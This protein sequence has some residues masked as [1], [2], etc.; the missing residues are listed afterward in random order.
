M[1]PSPILR[2][3]H[4]RGRGTV[5]RFRMAALALIVTVGAGPMLLDA[6]ILATKDQ[7]GCAIR[8]VVDGDT[9]RL[10]CPDLGRVNGRV[11]GIDTPELRG[12]CLSER[13]QALH[14]KAWLHWTF[15][16]ARSLEAKPGAPDLYNRPL[17]TVTVDGRPLSEMFIAAGLARPYDGGR[18]ES[19]CEE[20]R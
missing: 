18:R 6:A 4:V 5:R 13:L 2:R 9:V 12:H 19:W 20:E 15:W 10:T 11:T 14:A 16:S 7:S 8:G 1:R 3:P 17:T